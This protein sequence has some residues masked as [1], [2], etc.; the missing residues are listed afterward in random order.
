MCLCFKFLNEAEL[1]LTTFSY[2]K[3]FSFTSLSHLILLKNKKLQLKIV[4][5]HF[6][7]QVFAMCIF[8]RVDLNHFETLKSSQFIKATTTN[9]TQS[10]AI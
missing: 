9:L 8:V 5:V 6:P 4:I 10:S 2:L 3:S 7:F 1:S